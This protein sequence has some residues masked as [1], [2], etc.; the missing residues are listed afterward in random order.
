MIA[1]TA[2]DVNKFLQSTGPSRT[3]AFSSPNHPRLLEARILYLTQILH[4]GRVNPPTVGRVVAVPAR[5]GTRPTL[6]TIT[7]VFAAPAGR[8]GWAVDAQGS[9]RTAPKAILMPRHQIFEKALD[10]GRILCHYV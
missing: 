2:L 3:F 4:K 6:D 5:P 8:L 10:R 1:E 9:L 7:S